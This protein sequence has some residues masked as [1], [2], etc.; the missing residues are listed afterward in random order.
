MSDSTLLKT[1]RDEQRFHHISIISS[2]CR[3]TGVAARNGEGFL[4]T[5]VARYCLLLQPELLIASLASLLFFRSHS[6][7]PLALKTTFYTLDRNSSTHFKARTSSPSCPQAKVRSPLARQRSSTQ[8][9]A[10]QQ[11]SPV[12]RV[13]QPSTCST[14]ILQRARLGTA[15]DAL[16]FSRAAANDL[17]SNPIETPGT[18]NISNRF[19]SGGAKGEYTPGVAT[20][21]NSAENVSSPQEG[22]GR[23]DSAAERHLEQKHGMQKD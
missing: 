17:S 4:T 2:R 6:A 14:R 9:L 16:L 3:S 18:Q 8:P 12:S 1:S 22:E 21:R 5:Q 15:T 23:K 13:S 10:V 11:S 19:S 7:S 20:P